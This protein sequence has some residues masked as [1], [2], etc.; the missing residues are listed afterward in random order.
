MSYKI[1]GIWTLNPN[2]GKPFPASMETRGERMTR[3]RERKKL[4]ERIT[5]EPCR[6]RQNRREIQVRD[7]NGL[8]WNTNASFDKTFRTLLKLVYPLPIRFEIRYTSERRRC[9]CIEGCRLPGVGNRKGR[10][11]DVANSPGVGLSRG[12]WRIRGLVKKW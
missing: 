4:H 9:Q 5:G 7:K 12:R 1:N 10:A 2:N 3:R 6:R 8:S 11:T